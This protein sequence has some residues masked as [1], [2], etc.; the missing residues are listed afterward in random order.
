MSKHDIKEYLK[1][2]TPKENKG[3]KVNETLRS[4][5]IQLSL[6]DLFGNVYYNQLVGSKEQLIVRSL[7]AYLSGRLDISENRLRGEMKRYLKLNAIGTMTLGQYERALD[8][9]AA[10]AP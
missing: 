9:L 1:A 7:L 3:T 6:G 4:E 8:F 5:L 10:R 2:A